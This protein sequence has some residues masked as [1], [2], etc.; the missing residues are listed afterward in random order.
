MCG[1]RLLLEMNWILWVH[2]PEE[3]IL[4]WHICPVYFN[5]LYM[6]HKQNIQVKE[7]HGPFFFPLCSFEPHIWKRNVIFFFLLESFIC[8]VLRLSVE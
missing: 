1:S 6:L 2:K 8:L 7:S 4:K 3:M 5:F